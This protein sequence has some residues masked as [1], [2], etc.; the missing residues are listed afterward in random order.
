MN[1][2]ERLYRDI[3]SHLLSDEKP[4]VFLKRAGDFSAFQTYPFELLNRLRKTKQS[5]KYHPEGSVWNHTLL[6]VDEAAKRKDQSE[7]PDAFL[8]AALLH[9]IGK[10]STTKTRKGRITSYNHEKVGARLAEE[11]LNFFSAPRELIVAVKALVRWHMQ[12]LFVS[13]QLPFAQL[14]AMK[15]E[16]D[17]REVALLGLCDRL[18]RL[19]ADT[20]K[21]EENRRIFL[22][23]CEKAAEASRE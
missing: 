3:G 8:W 14:N 5:P 6:V 21:E 1:E 19:N 4:S 16:A 12:I 9:D 2:L 10:P 20:E 13:K 17:P 7:N 15:R 23:K 18:G 11:F 22:E